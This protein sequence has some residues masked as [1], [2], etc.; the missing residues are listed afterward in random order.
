[1]P[2]IL[3]REAYDLWL[4]SA[5]VDPATASAL[6]APAPE[7]LLEAIP[8]LTDVNRVANDNPKLVEPATVSAEPAPAPK[9]AAK[10]APAKRAKKNT[11]QTNGQGALF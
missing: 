10:R 3:A 9:P 5:D 1:M 4:N 7:N 6:I 11:K 2:V 8:V